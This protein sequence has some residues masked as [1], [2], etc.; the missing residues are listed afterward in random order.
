MGMLSVDDRC[1]ICHGGG[2]QS[3]RDAGGVGYIATCE[4]CGEFRYLDFNSL[5][6]TTQN[7]LSW[8]ALSCAARQA[9][10]SGQRLVVLPEKVEE[11]IRS[12]GSASVTE[13][14]ER[15]LRYLGSKLRRPSEV[16]RIDPETTFTV[17]DAETSAD[18]RIYL[19]WLQSDG[20]IAAPNQIG[21]SHSDVSLTKAGWARRQAPVSQKGGTPGTC[22]I[23]MW[24]DP[25]MTEAYD[26]GI[27]AAVEADCGFKAL[28]IDR[29]E[30]NNQITDE[31]M[32]GIRSAEF[33][34]ADF[35]KHRHG[36]YYEAG[37]AR[38]LGREVI[39]CCQKDSFEGRH[40]DTSVISHVVWAEPP[41]LR[42]KLAA[43][44]R[45]TILPKA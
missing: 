17:I 45:A 27:L 2:C 14:L 41:E 31:I 12:H 19:D 5:I 32:A 20:L 34:V 24:F 22:F 6:Q 38:G 35:T 44:I 16:L 8:H 1:P 33:M 7:G 18:F 28:R 11:I 4:L 43:R 13:N 39:Y 15:L 23:A 42:T 40:F 25:A 10:E 29:K 36:V 21:V 37:F 3:R 30:H 26:I 9:W